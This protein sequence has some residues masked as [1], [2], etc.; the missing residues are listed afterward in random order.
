MREIKDLTEIQGLVLDIFSEVDRFCR[1]NDL[2]YCLD[3][4]TLLGAVRHK[5]FIPWDDDIDI[6]MPR[7]DYVRFK[8]LFAQRKDKGH[9]EMVS[10]DTDTFY[11]R[12]MTKIIDTRTTLVETK[13]HGDD[14]I[15]TFV[16]I[17]PMDG[18]P[19]NKAAHFFHEKRMHFLKRLLFLKL[20]YPKT[21]PFSSK[22][23]CQ[24]LENGEAKIPYD[25]SE[26]V[27]CYSAYFKEYPKKW[28]EERIELPFGYVTAYAPVGYKE[29]LTELYGDYMKL[30]PKDKQVPNHEYSLYWKDR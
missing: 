9:L 25:D 12:A 2:R 24:M 17:F 3:S 28:F 26:I 30:P 8:Q 1:E 13:Y 10:W 15:G 29:I 16:D 27:T 23:I 21:V 7:P 6:C 20:L 14:P 5:G 4:G 18:V 22:R 11:G 19:K